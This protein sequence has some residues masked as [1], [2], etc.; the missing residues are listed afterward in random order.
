MSR[1]KFANQLFTP[2]GQFRTWIVNNSLSIGR[3]KMLFA[4]ISLA[5]HNSSGDCA[6]ATYWGW[7]AAARV[8]L[9]FGRRGSGHGAETWEIETEFLIC[10]ELLCFSY[11]PSPVTPVSNLVKCFFFRPEAAEESMSW[12]ISATPLITSWQGLSLSF[13]LTVIQQSLPLF[14]PLHIWST[15]WIQCPE[16]CN[17]YDRP[18]TCLFCTADRTSKIT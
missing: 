14:S 1:I 2:K 5:F 10:T 3:K 13:L 16:Y 11:L 4:S 8:L 18:P 7:L 6:E 12:C 9:I 17:P 15:W